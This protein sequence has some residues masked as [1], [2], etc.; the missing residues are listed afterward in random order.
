MQSLHMSQGIA[1]SQTSA[2]VASTC[3]KPPSHIQI[4]YQFD[5][6]FVD[7]KLLMNDFQL[8]CGSREDIE[9]LVDQVVTA[10]KA[11]GLRVTK[12]KLS[13]E[14]EF[15]QAKIELA[16]DKDDEQ[17]RSILFPVKY[18]ELDNSI[19]S[20]AEI[21]G[22]AREDEILV[23]RYVL[24][25][26][27]IRDPNSRVVVQWFRDG[28][29]IKGANKSRYKLTSA[30]VDGKMTA[31]I[32]VKDSRDIIYAQT[33]L[34]F[35]YKVGSVISLPEA[36]DLKIEGEAVVGKVVNAS[37]VYVD[38][39]RLDKEQNS[40]FV[41]L[42]DNFII[43]EASGPTYQIVPQD[44]GKRISVQVTPRNISNE[45]GKTVATEMEKIVEDELVTL[46]PDILN[47]VK[48][49]SKETDAFETLRVTKKVLSDLD[50]V[51]L[52]SKKME[53]PSSK[54][55]QDIYLTP[56]LSIHHSSPR[57]IT[58][59]IFYPNNPFSKSF[60]ENIK[61]QFFGN[62]ISTQRIEILLKRLNSELRDANY[63]S[64][65]SYLPEQVIKAGVLKI[66]FRKISKKA[67]TSQVKIKKGMSAFEFLLIGFGLACCL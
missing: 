29:Q 61:N 50:E 54:E 1:C 52:T 11:Q 30:D 40:Y 64:I 4:Y 3:P 42:R 59:I 60:S 33:K 32:F 63:N 56:D 66:Q 67:D 28:Q 6:S 55:T 17:P 24:D 13:M 7:Q 10:L 62:D 18:F 8:K 48:N 15:E 2:A 23:L 37:Y 44:A 53:N 9:W 16:T 20:H 51:K 49:F 26:G 58:D 19:L 46:R 39:N 41:W 36:R 12:R 57:K 25:D 45:T 27:R 43:K 65:E 21:S 38:R 34:S 5:W 35:P 47:G 31:F 22:I 14:T